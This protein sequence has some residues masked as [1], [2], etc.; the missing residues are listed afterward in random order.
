M[1]KRTLHHLTLYRRH[2]STCPIKDEPTKIDQCD[3]PMWV[4]GRLHGKLYR[5]AL[6]TRCHITAE[7]K[8]QDLLNGK[9]SGPDGDGGNVVALPKSGHITLAFATQE[10]LASKKKKGTSTQTLYARA[11]NH[12]TRWAEAQGVTLLA[13]VETHHLQK[14]FAEYDSKWRSSSSATRLTHLRVFFNY[15]IDPRRWIQH[16]PA[17]H[18]DLNYKKTAKVGKRLPLTPDEVTRVLASV[19]KMPAETRDRARALILLLLYTGM[20]ISDA[21]FFEREYVT[22]TNVAEYLVIKTRSKISLPPELHPRVIDALAALPASEVYFFQ[23][24]A[25]TAEIEIAREALREGKEF[26][27][28]MPGYKARVQ[29]ATKLVTDTLKLAGIKGACHRF[30]DTFAVNLLTQGVDIFTV[31]Q[32]LGHSDVS[33]TQDHYLKLIPGYRERMSQK[34]RSLAYAFPEVAA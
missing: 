12:F 33:I 28:L 30:R 15:C 26:W 19:E 16:S 1:T 8:K 14:Y 3:C 9:G 32:M 24:D 5:K 18:K 7:L 34:T 17:K 25:R 21:T 11:V 29:A 4:H 10:F 23:P 2:A 27:T 20:R 31:S 13:K 22:A 6:D